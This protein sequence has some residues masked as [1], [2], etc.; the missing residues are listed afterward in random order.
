MSSTKSRPRTS[1]KARKSARKSY[2]FCVECN[3]RFLATGRGEIARND[4]TRH[5][6]KSHGKHITQASNFLRTE[7]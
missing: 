6:V 2:I 3:A 4:A 1:F 5:V 7:W